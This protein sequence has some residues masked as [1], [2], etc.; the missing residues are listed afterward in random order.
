MIKDTIL[1]DKKEVLLYDENV[2]QSQRFFSSLLNIS[3]NLNLS[4]NYIIVFKW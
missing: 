1:T 2:I 3:F 4:P